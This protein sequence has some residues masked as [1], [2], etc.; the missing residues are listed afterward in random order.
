MGQTLN[1]LYQMN[2]FHA[3]PSVWK[4]TLDMLVYRLF[5]DFWQ[6]FAIVCFTICGDCQLHA[7][8]V[9][10]LLQFLEF[11]FVLRFTLLHDHPE[12]GVH[13]VQLLPLGVAGARGL[14]AFLQFFFQL[15]FLRLQ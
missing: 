2:P 6:Y 12:S 11:F 15:L 4:K 5:C 10:F 8:R 3:L 13:H 7:A 1:F 9:V 14:P